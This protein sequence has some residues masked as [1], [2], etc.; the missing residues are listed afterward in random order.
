[1]TNQTLPPEFKELLNDIYFPKELLESE[2]EDSL[3][4]EF[5]THPAQ[6]T[7]NLLHAS[8]SSTSKW[9]TPE[10][11]EMLQKFNLTKADIIRG[12]NK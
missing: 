5:S 9:D 6:F 12:S 8:A 11:R 4:T 1:M 7:R 2:G 3:Y 10:G